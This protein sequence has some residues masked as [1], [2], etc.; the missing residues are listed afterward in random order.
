MLYLL[1]QQIRFI[2]NCKSEIASPD[3]VKTIPKIRRFA[4]NFCD[5]DENADVFAAPWSR[6][7]T[8]PVL[9]VLHPDLYHS[10][11]T[12]LWVGL[13]SVPQVL[14]RIRT[15]RF[16]LPCVRPSS[17]SVAPRAF[18]TTRSGPFKTSTSF[19]SFPMMISPVS[20]RTTNCS[21]TNCL[22]TFEQM[23]KAKSCFHSPFDTKTYNCPTTVEKYTLEAKAVSQGWLEKQPKLKSVST[24]CRN[25]L[26][27]IMLK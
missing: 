6:F 16:I 25:T 14:S 21:W 22:P 12:P 9:T 3:I 27:R 19:E 2:P 13:S 20:P 26:I 1:C 5:M 4:Q 8:M 15:E 18:D 10:C 7:Q 17:I 24:S 11:T 23:A